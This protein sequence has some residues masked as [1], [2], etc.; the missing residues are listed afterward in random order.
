MCG[1]AG[2][3]RDLHPGMLAEIGARMAGSVRHRGPDRQAAWVGEGV[4]LAH[5]RLSIIDLSE[6]VPAVPVPGVS[7]RI[8]PMPGSSAPPLASSPPAC[9]SSRPAPP[10]APW[11]G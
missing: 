9:A 3:L 5:A 8:R 2:A 4:V 1:I 10:T 6:H 7:I 11:S